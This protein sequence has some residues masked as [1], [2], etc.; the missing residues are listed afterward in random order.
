MVTLHPAATAAAPR[1][2]AT[3]A[4]PPL[5]RTVEATG[6]PFTFLCDLVLKILYFN[7][8]MLG[9]DIARH[10]CLPFPLVERT[11]KFL[12]DEGYCTTTG[13]RMAALDEGE[14][15]GTGLQFLISTTGRARA[16]DLIQLNQYAGPAPVPV[17]DYN[18]VAQHQATAPVHVA[19]A[20]L[21]QALGHLVVSEGVLDRLGPALNARQAIFLYGPPGNGK[22]SI[23][24]SCAGLLGDPLFVP[25]ALYVHGEVIRFFDPVHHRVVEMGL[26]PYD[27]RWQLIDRPV[28]RVGGELV[29]RM[30][31]LG[32]DPLLGFYDAS[33]Q[34]KANGGLFLVDDFG[35]QQHMRTADLIN[36][37]IIPLERGVDH[38]DIARGGTSIAVPFTTLLV[39]STNLHPRDLVDEAFLR[40]VRFK[41]LVPNPTQ[42]EYLEIWQRECQRAELP[43]EPEAIEH[44]MERHYRGAGRPLRGVHPRD[45]LEHVVHAARY[46]GEPARLT[47]ASLD[48]ACETYFVH[49]TDAP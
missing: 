1:V 12:S 42:D 15:I 46:R 9:G 39:L 45:L 24:E 17:E 23:A 47:P 27:R 28:V 43:W 21:T 26:P 25:H 30:L 10:V 31:D 19:P 4:Y 11:L 7:G 48:L 13:V 40:R 22:T 5:P 16:R 35:R 34:L 3:I 18:V 41:M 36:R 14:S 38:L 44:L 33:L 20:A 37:L 49:L 29:P 2:P 32:F 6:L 8:G